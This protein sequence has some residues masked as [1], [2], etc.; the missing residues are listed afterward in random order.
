MNLRGIWQAAYTAGVVLPKPVA[1]AQYWHR[2]LNPKKLIGVG[3]SRLAVR[4]LPPPPPPPP[5]P[6]A[7]VKRLS[8]LPSLCCDIGFGEGK[9]LLLLPEHVCAKS[10]QLCTMMAR[11]NKATEGLDN[12]ADPWTLAF[13]TYRI[14]RVQ[15]LVADTVRLG[16]SSRA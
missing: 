4:T 8:M 1:T 16:P 14:G 10:A 15:T 11:V 6:C 12:G 3:F 7:S 9:C 5:W 2:S 13:N